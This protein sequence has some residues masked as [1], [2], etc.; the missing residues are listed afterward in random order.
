VT[1]L[2]DKTVSELRAQLPV[3]LTVAETAEVARCSPSS[4]RRAIEAGKLPFNQRGGEGGAIY[5][6]RDAV[7]EWAFM[8][9]ARPTRAKT[10]HSRQRGTRHTPTERPPSMRR[11]PLRLTIG[12]TPVERLTPETMR[13]LAAA[14]AG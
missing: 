6:P 2:L 1:N 7:L 13:E 10:P 4:V 14:Y 3:L 9:E 12:G 5:V 11:P 8:L